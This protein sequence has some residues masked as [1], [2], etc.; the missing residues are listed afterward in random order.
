MR[1]GKTH[2]IFSCKVRDAW[3]KPIKGSHMSTY[4][5]QVEVK[6]VFSLLTF[7]GIFSIGEGLLN[8]PCEFAPSA[9]PLQ[10]KKEIPPVWMNYSMHLIFMNV[11]ESS[12]L[13]PHEIASRI[14]TFTIREN[15]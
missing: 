10:V 1:F 15:V 6:T 12:N 11:N 5:S 7:L 4:H 2:I 13:I 3:K 8:M 14:S 9:P